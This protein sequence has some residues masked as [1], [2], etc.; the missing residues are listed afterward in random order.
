M[1]K[2]STAFRRFQAVESYV[3]RVERILLLV[4]MVLMLI[5]LALGILTR[6]LR[7]TA[8]WTN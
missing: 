4:T 5:C 6:L 1:S 3:V 7:I 8:P 2:P